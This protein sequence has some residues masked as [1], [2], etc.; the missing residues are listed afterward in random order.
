MILR[1]DLADFAQFVAAETAV[2]REC[3][4]LQ[5]EFRI[6][7]GVSNVDV[8]WLSSLETVKK[9]SVTTNPQKRRHRTSLPLSCT[10]DNFHSSFGQT[11]SVSLAA[12]ECNCLWPETISVGQRVATSEASSADL[13]RQ[14]KSG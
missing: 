3:N 4:R 5:P 13:V 12:S 11:G 10:T 1:D 14:D 6:T 2:V 9:E 8:R 7:A